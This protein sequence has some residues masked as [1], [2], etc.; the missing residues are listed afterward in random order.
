MPVSLRLL[1]AI[2]ALRPS[3]IYGFTTS[4]VVVN[5]NHHQDR[6]SSLQSHPKN[7]QRAHIE[8]NL[9][10]AMDNDW[11][12]FRARL[13]AKE[14]L[15]LQDEKKKKKSKKNAKSSSDDNDHSA[16]S[17]SSSAEDNDD[18]KLQRQAQLSDL[19]AGALSSI[20]KPYQQKTPPEPSS[21]TSIFAGDTV[22][23][24]HCIPTKNSKNDGVVDN[25]EDNLDVM[26]GDDD[27][28][29]E[30]FQNE[31]PFASDAELPLRLPHQTLIDKHRWAHEIPYI[32]P[33]AVLVANEK[34][35]GVFHQTVVLVVEHHETT[36][37]F[38]IVINR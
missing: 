37:T 13:V 32:E 20:F 14:K 2:L 38:G 1:I 19:F 26:A 9:E 10:E 23:G 6:H 33:G 4:P 5:R 21:D 27:N 35:G 22:G 7:A 11:R 3:L 34:L 16:K 12:V 31:D 29:K 30:V 8:R 18:P 36:G 15:E 28:D 25:E 17:H 24:A